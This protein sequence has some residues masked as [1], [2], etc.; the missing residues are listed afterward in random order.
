M[1]F[2]NGRSRQLDARRRDKEA[3]RPRGELLEDRM[4]LTIDLGGTVPS[5]NPVI[6][7]TPYGLD[8]AMATPFPNS[9]NPPSSPQT[10]VNAGSGWSVSDLGNIN[11]SGYDSFAIGAPSITNPT[12][13]T[14]QTG[15]SVYV[16]FGSSSITNSTTASVEV[17]DWIAKNSSG[18]YVWDANNR[19][20]NMAEVTQAPYSTGFLQTNPITGAQLT[21]QIPLIRFTGLA[22]SITGGVGASVSSV[23]MPNGNY[24]ILIGAPFAAGSSNAGSAGGRA[25]LVYGDFNANFGQ[26]INLDGTPPSGLTIITFDTSVAGSQLGFSVA[27][28]SNI[29]GDGAGD[30]ILGAPAASVGTTSTNTGAVYVI[31]T[32]ALPT[33]SQTIDVTTF[34]QSGASNSAIFAGA[35]AGARAGFSVADAGNVNGASGNVDDLLIG[36]PAQSGGGAAYLIYGGSGLASLAQTV[37]GVRYIN[38]AKVGA[39]STTTGA[40]PGATILG[41]SGSQ[42]GFAVSSG[43]YFNG[44]TTYSDILIGSPYY[45]TSSLTN[46]GEATLLYGAP[47]SSTSYL[48]GTINLT[49]PPSTIN[50]LS[51]TGAAANNLAGYSVS[52]VGYITAGQQSLVLVGA[53]GFNN[54]NGAAYL[55]PGR[56]GGLIGS[57]SLA[58][59]ESAP[60]SGQQFVLTTPAVSTTSPPFFGASVSSRFQTTSVTADG[61]SKADFIIGAPGYSVTQSSATTQAGG[62]MIIE[63]G[64]IPPLTPSSGIVTSIGIDQ[65]KGP[66]AIN[67]TTPTNLSIYVFGTTT[68]T[69]QV[70]HPVTDINPNAPVI[71]DGYSYPSAT[72]I[73]DPNQA[74]W[75]NGIQDAILVVSPRSALNLTN[76]LQNMTVSGSILSTSP[77]AGLTWNGVAQV[78][79]TGAPTPTPSPSSALVA[80]APP[81]PITSTTYNSTF[82]ASQFVP[83]ISQFSAYNYA[84]IPLSVAMQQYLPPPGF[85]ERIYQFNHRGQHLKNYL[86]LR[87]PAATGIFMEKQP[88]LFIN[89][90][91]YDRSRFHPGK[92]LTYTHRAPNIGNVYK[93]VVPVQLKTQNAMYLG[94]VYKDS[95]GR[96]GAQ[97]PQGL[98]GGSGTG[99]HK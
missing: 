10:V 80:V 48:T 36:A 70:F 99:I 46:V 65:P 49:S 92:A 41:P 54:N 51:L 16:V 71:V 28:G 1:L 32:A 69:G 35:S 2:G 6:A 75:L 38:L 74:D 14:N 3:I 44:N 13:L 58:S 60:L 8:F 59:A 37:N 91:V 77:L 66:F 19:V 61:D 25:Y 17:N 73:P 39:A 83:T 50:P 53:P 4:L 56:T 81:G 15:S 40:V 84:P 86:T 42:T 72:L 22:A 26:T 78:T 27:G 68:S 96:G 95:V 29:F 5:I 98:P 76:G 45:S 18:S 11:G 47:S 43:G 63:G 7:T 97:M 89:W 34:G 62:A 31:S 52:P 33:T 79:V 94:P 12:T 55:L 88:R 20:A 90:R 57:Y 82:G 87:G 67:A 85:N 23:R 30:V 21:N 9:S 24:G 64:L 93:G